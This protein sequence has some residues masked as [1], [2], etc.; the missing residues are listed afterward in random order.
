MRTSLSAYSLSLLLALASDALAAP[1]PAEPIGKSMTLSKRAVN[2]T[3][4]E[5]GVW[6]KNHRDYL[7]DKYAAA[8]SAKAKGKARRSSGTNLI[9]NQNADSTY[10]GSLAI[11][12]PPVAFDVIL[13]TGSALVM[14]RHILVQLIN[15][16]E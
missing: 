14:L 12:T 16:F 5:W 13:D 1:N 10:F 8:P 3:Y 4:D 15:T 11:G 2:R 9:V 7:I 6:A